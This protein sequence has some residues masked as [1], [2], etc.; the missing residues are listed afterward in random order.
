MLVHK[1][2]DIFLRAAVEVLDEVDQRKVKDLDIEKDI[3][4]YYP[5]PMYFWFPKND[6]GRRLAARAE[7]GMRAMI[8][9]GSYDRIFDQYQRWKIERLRLK[10][11]RI[12]RIDNP[13][14]GPE[15]PF[16]DKRLWFEPKT[17]K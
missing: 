11:R 16:A 12:F 7:E 10:S 6:E 17:Y 13:F 4:F 2:F 5:L 14:L 8:A 3:V 15:T 9:D 1:R